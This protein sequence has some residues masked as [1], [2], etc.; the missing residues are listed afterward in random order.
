MTS[1]DF[2]H[3]R[4]N[5]F[6]LQLSNKDK[7]DAKHVVRQTDYETIISNI[8][9]EDTITLTFDIPLKDNNYFEKLILTRKFDVNCKH[10]DITLS[11]YNDEEV[12]NEYHIKAKSQ[13]VNN[14]IE[15]TTHIVKLLSAKSIAWNKIIYSDSIMT[16]SSQ[17]G[18]I[19]RDRVNNGQTGDICYSY[20][21][22][23][24][25][26]NHVHGIDINYTVDFRAIFSIKVTDNILTV[27]KCIFWPQSVII[28][29]I[30]D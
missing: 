19:K 28:Q 27:T 7:K 15:K 6:E 8:S 25:F 2:L 11:I 10:N 9:N 3:T 17:N 22:M 5:K 18:N 14:V 13:I 21:T 26:L 29:K 24:T 16:F 12:G 23:S 1:A 4:D 20:L 30:D